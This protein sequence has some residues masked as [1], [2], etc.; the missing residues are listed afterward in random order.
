[1]AR[2]HPLTDQKPQYLGEEELSEDYDSTD[3]PPFITGKKGS[4]MKKR[5]K[6]PAVQVPS[7]NGNVKQHFEL[8]K[9]KPLTINQ[10][11][12]FDSY[13]QGKNL[14]LHGY[15]GTGKTFISLHLA[16]KEILTGGSVYDKIII[17]R[18]VVPSREIGFLPGNYKE[19]IRVYEDPYKEICDD[20]F[21]RGDGYDILQLKGIVQFT[22]TS[23]LRGMTYNNAIVI[24][25]E[26]QNMVFQE[27]D[28]VMTR[29]GN[30]SKII[31]CGDFRQT[32]LTTDSEKGGLRRFMSILERMENFS[33]IEFDKEDIVRSGLVKSYIIHKTELGL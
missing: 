26:I 3:L 19:K 16:L 23:F 32:D 11:K 27:I 28:T 20:L 1:M 17:I 5:N 7:T 2:I 10:Q 8:R 14:L 15:A 12:T 18:S 31:F 24:V 22:T 13:D 6:N 9:I 30:Q 21:D 25:D 29:L 4:S 33:H